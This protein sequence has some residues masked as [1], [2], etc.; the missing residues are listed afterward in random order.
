[1]LLKHLSK[2]YYSPD[3][4]GAGGGQ[5]QQVDNGGNNDSKDPLDS[6]IEAT[7]IDE[8]GNKGTEGT[9][10]NDQGTQQRAQDQGNQQPQRGTGEAAQQQPNVQLPAQRGHLPADAKGNLVDPRTGQVIATAGDGRRWYEENRRTSMQLT[11]SKQQLDNLNVQLSA[12]KEANASIERLGIDPT[13]H[14]M[15]VQ[16][17]ANYKKDPVGT[18]K[19]MLTEA[20]AAGHNLSSILGTA[21]AFDPAAIKQMI[22]SEI[23]PLRQSQ[24][25]EAAI[26]Q[27]GNEAA[28]EANEFYTQHPD[29]V[30][31]DAVLV[32]L[33][34]RNTNLSPREAY[35]E[36]KLYA[37]EK[38]LDWSRPLHSQVD[39]NGSVIQ[40]TQ[41][42]NGQRPLVTQG[43]PMT[44]RGG[45][46]QPRNDQAL[47]SEDMTSSDIVRMAMREQGLMR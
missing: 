46:I 36:L 14:L 32:Q 47:A 5:D 37:A 11:Q 1:M 8:G 44:G 30:I 6:F 23:A 12:Y 25:R 41:Q 7:T 22:A 34:E 35:L 18:F 27:A 24:E 28:A 17:F 3:D 43:A 31:H 16:L 42:S 20:Q 26:Q 10:P 4:E 38:G 45:N 9:T 40:R 29:A 15:A 19:W 2:I 21:G 39:Q 13:E 33:M